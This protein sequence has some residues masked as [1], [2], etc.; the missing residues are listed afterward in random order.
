MARSIVVPGEI[1]TTERKGLGINVYMQAG[2]IHSTCLGIVEETPEKASVIPLEGRYMPGFDDL[3]VGVVVG[4]RM[5]GYSV[6]INS[7]YPAFVSKRDTRENLKIGSVISAKVVNVNE[8]NEA[9][10]GFVRVFY[11]GEVLSISPVKVPR[12][13]GK[14]ASMLNILKMGTASSV[15]VG[16]NGRIWAKGGNTKLLADAIDKIEREAHTEH[17]TEKMEKFLKLKPGA[18]NIEVK[19]ENQ[20]ERDL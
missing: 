6:D 14:N 12:V 16:R 4:E 11:G 8:V 3:V 18:S 13:I 10:L 5:A 1:I 20:E 17:L 19:N 7:F 2:K 9:D 15:L